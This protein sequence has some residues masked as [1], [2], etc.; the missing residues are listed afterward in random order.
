MKRIVLDKPFQLQLQ[1]VQRPVA[2]ADEA[3]VHIRRIGIC[4]TDLHAYQGNQ[5]FFSYPRILGHELS[6]E[7]VEI[8][9]NEHRLR[10]GDRCVI[11]PYLA[12]GH[13]IACRNGKTNCC[14]GL[15][16]LGVH[17]DGGM[18]EYLAVPVA[19]LI[20]SESLTF[21][22]LALVENQCIGAH[23]VRRAN[24]RQG[25]FALV[26]GAG[27]I[28]L[29]VLQF[30]K[31]AG[32]HVIAMDISSE[33][34]TFCRE[35]FQLE[36]AILAGP[37]ARDALRAITDGDLATAVF[38]ATGNTRAMRQSLDYLAHGGRLIYIGFAQDEIGFFNPDFH[39]KET[40]LL[41]SRNA[42]REDFQH[43]I[44]ALED[45]R[46]AVDRFIT[47]RAGLD[48]TPASFS[49]WIDPAKRVIK[50]VVEN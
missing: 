10:I 31:L 25:E 3:L 11:N 40:T 33:R 7:I 46:A 12:C 13:C 23:A 34:L 48:A 50:A 15:E 32:A 45:G 39:K 5:P 26:V 9:A 38:D 2:A 36:H 6:G 17:T 22:Q 20:R 42:T 43:V 24:L 8:G 30:A 37:D 14:C 21:D 41:G 29:G 4:G 18:Q 19:Q 28:G 27:P 44:G 16:V 47:H 35:C 1:D 49:G